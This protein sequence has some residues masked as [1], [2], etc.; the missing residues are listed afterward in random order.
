MRRWQ[1][2]RGTHAVIAFAFVLIS[3]TALAQTLSQRES[4]TALRAFDQVLRFVERNY[5]EP[6]DEAELYRGA[7]AALED[8]IGEDRPWDDVDTGG[9][10]RL[11]YLEAREDLADLSG[12]AVLEIA[13]DGLFQGLGDPY[14]EYLDSSQLRQLDDLTEGEFGGLGMYIAKEPVPGSDDPV[15]V[16]VVSPMQGT[17]AQAA[18]LRSG[19]LILAVDGASTDEITLDEAVTLIRGRPGTDVN[20]RIRRGRELEFDVS[21]TRDTIELPVVWHDFITPD[22][23]YIRLITFNAFSAERVQ[24]AYDELRAGGMERLILDVRGNAGGLLS[25]AIDTAS[26]FLDGG[27][28]VETRGRLQS[29]NRAYNATPGQGISPDVPLVLMIDGASASASEILAGALRDSGRATLIGETTF[30]KGSVQSYYPLNTPEQSGFKLT[31]SLFYAPAGQRIHGAGISPDVVAAEPEPS[32][33]EEEA[34]AQI[35]EDRRIRSFLDANPNADAA[36]IRRFHRELQ[37]EGYPVSERRVSQLVL[38]EQD[39]RSGYTRVFDLD[40]DVVLQEA[41]DL[42]RSL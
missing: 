40:N 35:S 13:L 21:V 19:D 11:T 30:G 34:L 10:F 4:L 8:A 22:V 31:R 16:T 25:A 41:L 37:A 3:A 32:E 36:A 6:I 39:R 15:F 29:E 23:G 12:D 20:L 33:E 38:A 9:E 24:A 14:S 5:V 18:G 42:I 26:L 17:P 7:A 1:R 2:T 27:V 28:V